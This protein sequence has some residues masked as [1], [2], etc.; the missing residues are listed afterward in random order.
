M[1]YDG[2]KPVTEKEAE[3]NRQSIQIQIPDPKFKHPGS[4]HLYDV[5]VEASEDRVASYFGMRKFS[6][7]KDRKGYTRLFLNNQPLFQFDPLDQ[8]Y[9]P[10]GS[11]TPPTDQAMHWDLELVKRLGFNM[12]R[13]NVKV[14]PARYYYYCDRMGL[15]VWQDML[16]GGKEVGEIPTLLA[17][18]FGFRRRDRNYRYAG[19]EKAASRDD[20]HRE[21]LELVDH[22]WNPSAEFGYKKFTTSDAFTEAYLI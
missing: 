14:E 5:V 18:T 13:K 17:L 8:G 19:R 16:N 12:L 21:L 3:S 10:D 2:E 22:L 6:L 20:Y 7:G 1:V 4:P 9:W 11:Y 15:I